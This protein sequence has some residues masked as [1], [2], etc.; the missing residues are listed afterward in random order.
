M[1]RV[2]ALLWS[3]RR[4]LFAPRG[5]ALA[6]LIAVLAPGCAVEDDPGF[7]AGDDDDD[8][9][10]DSAEPEGPVSW[11]D[12]VVCSEPV[13]GFDRLEPRG[14]APFATAPQQDPG[15]CM[16]VYG[17]VAAEDLDGDGDID[18]AVAQSHMP[19]LLYRNAGDG[20]FDEVALPAFGAGDGR[21]FLGLS[22]VDL[23]G[24][25]LPEIVLAGEGFVA[26][27]DNLGGLGFAPF[28][29]VV[30]QEGYPRSCLHSASAGDLDGDGDLDLFVPG[31]DLLLDADATYTIDPVHAAEDLLLLQGPSGLAVAH[32]LLAPVSDM[33]SLVALLTDFD[34]DRDPDLLV[35]PDRMHMLGGGRLRLQVNE[36]GEFID[37]SSELGAD[38]PL[39]GGMGVASADL[40]GDGRLDYCFSDAVPAFSCL[41][42]NDLGFVESGL[43]LGLSVD[44]EGFP[45]WAGEHWNGWSVELVD[46]DNDGWL[47]LTCP[48]SHPDLIEVEPDMLFRGS[49]TGFVEAG[50][51]Q[52]FAS[53]DDHTGLAIADFAGDG[54]PDLVVGS[55]DGRPQFWNN[56]CGADRWIDLELLGPPGNPRG[57]GARVEIELAERTDVREISA[58]RG[59]GQ[60][61]AALHVGLG[62]ALEARVSVSWPDGEV[63]SGTVVPSNRVVTVRHP[64]AEGG[65]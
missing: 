58:G 61:P 64:A 45:E 27:A 5:L 19:P 50:T 24:D 48:A 33:I 43:S 23:N 7:A 20:T 26:V 44:G 16:P 34:G 30:F 46:L 57:I 53:L 22:L 52:G 47:D 8:D 29:P 14:G 65:S 6:L 11:S 12:E 15:R 39:L 40:N 54:Y 51:A 17:A 38:V 49:A 36:G 32:G 56:P 55:R 42:S 37:S 31:A 62:A 28:D 41:L 10:D 18:L 1:D 2:G 35:A 9:D 4:H 25:R 63:L 21:Q 13:N 3:V 59:W 60:S